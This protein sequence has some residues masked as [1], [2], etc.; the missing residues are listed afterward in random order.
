MLEISLDIIHVQIQEIKYQYEYKKVHLYI[1]LSNFY[2]Y[3]YEIMK[4]IDPKFHFEFEPNLSD[5]TFLNDFVCLYTKF[6]DNY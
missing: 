6:F 3:S 5:E 1:R 4:I 2:R